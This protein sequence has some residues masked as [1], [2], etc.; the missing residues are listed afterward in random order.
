MPAPRKSSRD[1]R[2]KRQ[3]LPVPSCLKARHS[4]PRA[5]ACASDHD[6]SRLYRSPNSKGITSASAG[7]CC[8]SG[9]CRSARCACK[10]SSRR[11]IP[12]P[13]PDRPTSPRLAWPKCRRRRPTGILPANA[14]D[15]QLTP[16]LVTGHCAKAAVRKTKMRVPMFRSRSRS[17]FL[18]SCTIR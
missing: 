9:S 4:A 5:P 15:L 7:S 16:S 12:C 11:R 14:H 8:S 17:A 6:L 3:S 2:S 1:V 18:F 13:M 10:N